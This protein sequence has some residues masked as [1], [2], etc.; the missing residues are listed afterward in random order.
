MASFQKRNGK[1]RVQVRKEGT[2]LCRTF[3]SMTDARK[4]ATQ[5]E[6]TIERGDLPTSRRS[7][8]RTVR[9]SEVL[10][11]YGR[12]VTPAKK[13]AASEKYRLKVLVGSPMAGKTLAQLTPQDIAG[14]RDARLRKVTCGTVRRDLALLRRVL[15][16]ARSEWDLPLATNPVVSIRLPS[17]APART[18]RLKEGEL[19]RLLESAS[20]IMGATVELLLLTGMR[21]SE[22]VAATWDN[23]DWHGCTLRL[24]TSKNGEGRFVP[25]SARAIEVLKGLSRSDERII[26]LSTNAVRL[27][28]QRLKRRAGVEGLRMHDLR[29]EAASRAFEK[30]LGI[31][32]DRAI[33]AGA[34][35]KRT[36]APRLWPC[37]AAITASSTA[38]FGKSKGLPTTTTGISPAVAA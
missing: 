22:L 15:E 9:L 37:I 7:E 19:D 12:E 30:G 27:A 6:A 32:P 18:R 16:V 21:R 35:T 31:A 13:G 25:L 17:D 4:W 20:P 3:T 33:S 8:L 29:R 24:L 10:A 36:A 11:R 5:Q 26:P 34:W 38:G 23:V 2:Y 14:W 1:V 28:W